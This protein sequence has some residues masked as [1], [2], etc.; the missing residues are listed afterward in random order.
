MAPCRRCGKTRDWEKESEYR[1][2]LVSF[3]SVSMKSEEP[4]L[5]MSCMLMFRCW[6]NAY[7]PPCL[8][9]RMRQYIV[10]YGAEPYGSSSMTLGAGGSFHFVADFNLDSPDVFFQP[11]PEDLERY[12]ELASKLDSTG[13]MRLF[14]LFGHRLDPMA[15]DYANIV[16]R[17]VAYWAKRHY[18]VQATLPK[19]Q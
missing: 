3:C 9:D 11:A 15:Q 19:S 18:E 12:P 2:K 4:D 14:D 10:G 16:A 5:C 8:E 6:F 17:A 7:K 1:D 13:L